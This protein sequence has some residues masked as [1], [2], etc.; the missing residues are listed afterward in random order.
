[1][2]RLLVATSL[3]LLVAG[4]EAPPPAASIPAT[5][6]PATISVPPGSAEDRALWRR[7]Y[8]LNNEIPIE[9]SISTRLQAE[10][11]SGRLLERLAQARKAPG[12]G[13]DHHEQI[14]HAERRLYNTLKGNAELTLSQWPVDPTRVCGYP[15]LN[16]ESVMRSNDGAQKPPQ[17]AQTRAA[18]LECVGKGEVPL[19]ALRASNDGVRGAISTA[20][21]VLVALP[22]ADA[23]R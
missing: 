5:A 2:T 9:R 21:Q 19:A 6:D 8:D 12:T 3:A 22:G 10:A 23:A 14:E 18:L 16:F 17:L 1:M 13:H 15:L 20:E 7:A 4:T 11:A